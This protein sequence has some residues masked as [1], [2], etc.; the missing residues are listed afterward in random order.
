MGLQDGKVGATIAVTD[1]SRAVE[2]YEGK[3]GL[4]SIEGDEPDGGRT[5]ECGAG[6]TLHVF[7]SPFA[8]ASGATVAGWEVQ[9]VAGTV[10]E[11]IA[12]GVTFEQY[13]DGT[14]ATDEKGLARLGDYVGAW[15][16]DPDGNVVAIGSEQQR[17]P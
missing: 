6:T 10:D 11:L 2:F 17:S 15:A 9:D 3:L 13:A 4:R 7:P 16:K 8:K 12:H 14:V 1:M 5:Y